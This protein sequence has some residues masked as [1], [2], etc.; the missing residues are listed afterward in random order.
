MQ[1]YCNGKGFSFMTKGPMV[2]LHLVCFDARHT[3]ILARDSLGTMPLTNAA[4]T[5][6]VNALCWL[7]IATP[8]SSCCHMREATQLFYIYKC[9]WCAG[10]LISSTRPTMSY[11]LIDTDYWSC[12]GANLHFDPLFQ[13]YLEQT[14]HLHWS[15]LAPTDLTMCPEAY[16]TTIGN[17]SRCQPQLPTLLRQCTFKLSWLI[18][19]WWMAKGTCISQSC[20]LSLA[21]CP[22]LQPLWPMNS[23]VMSERWWILIGLSTLFPMAISFWPLNPEICP[24]LFVWLAIPRNKDN[25][26]FMSLPV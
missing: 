26:F 25:H 15:S 16:L 11:E 14:H 24:L 13:K 23:N 9:D 17:V 4:S 1:D 8:S 19:S 10:M 3:L 21:I 5:S 18:S 6:S 2:I 20:Q 7:Q 22:Q 12:L